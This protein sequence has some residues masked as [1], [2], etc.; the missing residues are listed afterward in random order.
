M[1]ATFYI[2]TTLLSGRTP[3]RAIG[4][5]QRLGPDVRELVPD[6]RRLVI[7]RNDALLGHLRGT[8]ADLVLTATGPFGHRRVPQIDALGAIGSRLAP[9]SPAV[10]PAEAKRRKVRRRCHPDLLHALSRQPVHAST[11]AQ[12]TVPGGASECALVRAGC[13]TSVLYPLPDRG[14]RFG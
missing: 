14:E 10:L 8:H 5:A 7:R 12:V 13:G 3:D 11:S 9:D 1:L 6:P 4:R 2:A